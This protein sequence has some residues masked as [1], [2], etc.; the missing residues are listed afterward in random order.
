MADGAYLL[1]E[2][3]L[4]KESMLEELLHLLEEELYSLNELD[5]E[6]LESNAEKKKELYALVASSTR[7]SRQVMARLAE[8]MGVAGAESLS[9]LLPKVPQPERESLQV[10]QKKLL[11]LGKKVDQASLRNTNI[12]QGSL[13]AVNNSLEFFFRV[14][15]RSTTY[16]DAG[17]MVGGA[18]TPKLL[19]REA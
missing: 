10:A 14:F 12:L 11:E 5:V 8:E 17:R 6:K 15:N 1:I 4:R 13:L 9:L 3:L 2:Q 16:G 19:R 18:T 7:D